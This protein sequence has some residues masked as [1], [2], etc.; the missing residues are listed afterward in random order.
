[1]RRSKRFREEALSRLSIS[2]GAEQKFQRVSPRI[3]GAIE[4]HPHL[5]H[6]HIRFINAPRVARSFEVRAASSFQFRCVLLNP[7]VDRR[8]IDV[9]ATLPHHFLEVSI[10]Q[11]I[12]QIPPY[13]QEND[14]CLEMTPFERILT[15][16]AHEKEPLSLFFAYSS[17][18]IFF[19]QHSHFSSVQ[20][21]YLVYN[22]IVQCTTLFYA[23]TTTLFTKN[24]VA[25]SQI[26]FYV[27]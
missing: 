3:Y 24:N 23:Y 4:V 11:R 25:D 21:Y 19:L 18:S 8:M 6:F 13:A 20:L 10:T 17:R 22:F 1:M 2:C 12:A 16:T 26:L 9:Q 27:H 5:L 15:L 7:A 14:V